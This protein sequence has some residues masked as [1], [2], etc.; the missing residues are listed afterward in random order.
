MKKKILALMFT[1][2]MIV[3]CMAALTACGGDGATFGHTHTWAEKYTYNATQHWKKCVDCDETTDKEN[4]EL[5]DGLCSVCGYV[6]STKVAPRKQ[7]MSKY[8]SGVKA[9]YKKETAVDSDGEA[10]DFKTLVDRQIDVLAQDL[11]I[12]LNYVYHGIINF[13]NTNAINSEEKYNTNYS[14]RLFKGYNIVVPALVKS[15]LNNKFENTDVSIYPSFSKTAVNYTSNTE[16][17]SEA[18][19]YETITLLAKAN[20]P[21]TKLAMKISG[22]N[23]VGESV[24]LKY[25]VY[26]NGERKGAMSRIDLTNDEQIIEIDKFKERGKKFNAYSG[27]NTSD[28]NTNI[29]ENSVVAD[30]D[31][32]GYIK[33]VFTNDSGVKFKVTFDGYYDKV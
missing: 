16:G 10:K 28:L 11:L 13:A 14:P 33:I 9:T 19:N 23:I 32:D 5:T 24:K 3:P 18:Q 25:Q 7:A 2:C 21:Y 20:T 29:F 30:S 22:S 15:A 12:R 1:V 4:H 27:N 31:T 6:D 17:F 26:V 8:F